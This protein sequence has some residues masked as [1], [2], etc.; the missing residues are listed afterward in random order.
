MLG[1]GVGLALVLLLVAWWFQRNISQIEVP[2]VIY[3]KSIF[4]IL[5]HRPHPVSQQE[6]G[7]ISYCSRDYKWYMVARGQGSR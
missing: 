4:V 2:E 7:G 3:R 6:N 1:T 5:M